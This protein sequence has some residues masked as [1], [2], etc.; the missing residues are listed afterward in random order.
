MKEELIGQATPEQIEEWKNKYG[1][2]MAIKVDG[3]ICY[4]KSPDRK[5]L[6]YASQ[7]AKTNPMKF[8]EIVL[9]N[10]FV[11]G[12]EAI[13]TDDMLFLGASSVLEQLIEIKE[14]ELVK[15]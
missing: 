8:N 12:S 4:L 10:C 11:G 7:A 13:K 3:H 14:A 2:M 5:T 15:L 6:G 9:T 1:K